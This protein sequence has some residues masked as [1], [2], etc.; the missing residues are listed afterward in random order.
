MTDPS[1]SNPAP[2]VGTSSANPT[3][4]V[5]AASSNP[6]VVTSSS[7]ATPQVEDEKTLYLPVFEVGSY[8]AWSKKM[9]DVLTSQHLWDIVRSGYKPPK[10]ATELANWG[11]SQKDE[12]REAQNKNAKAWMLIRQAVG[13]E[14]MERV[15]ASDESPENITGIIKSFDKVISPKASNLSGNVH[16]CIPLI[17]LVSKTL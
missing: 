16:N 6:Q 10:D 4:R 1:S 13:V 12:Y 7:R 9:E 11:N 5:V 8:E 3:P 2:Q 15:F 17:I 14:I